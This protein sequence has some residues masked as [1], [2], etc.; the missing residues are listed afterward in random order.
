MATE[1]SEIFYRAHEDDSEGGASLR[2]TELDASYHIGCIVRDE[3]IPLGS[4]VAELFFYPHSKTSS[5][6]RGVGSEV[7]DLIL[8]EVQSKGIKVVY[9]EVTNTIAEKFFRKSGFK[10]SY[11]PHCYRVT[12]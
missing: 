11:Q 7:L 8:Q 5:Q 10:G 1:R 3:N 12:A 9:G 6:R 2:I 4:K